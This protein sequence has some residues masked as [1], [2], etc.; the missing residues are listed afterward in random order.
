MNT[1]RVRVTLRCLVSL[2]TMVGVTATT[3]AQIPSTNYCQTFRG[4]CAITGFGP[5]GYPC[6]CGS[7]QGHLV[8]PPSYGTV[9]STQFGMCLYPQAPSEW[10][11]PAAV[12]PGELSVNEI[13]L[14]AIAAKAVFNTS[15]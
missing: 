11:A 2:V 5:A 8:I 12:L 4:V 13:H 3:L 1:P 6:T 15:R 7:D 14:L 10:G 9:C